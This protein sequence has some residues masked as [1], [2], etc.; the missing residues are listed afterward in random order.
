MLS[1]HDLIEAWDDTML[2]LWNKGRNWGLSANGSLFV[3]LDQI[4]WCRAVD[5]LRRR[6]RFKDVG[7][8]LEEA[9][10]TIADRMQGDPVA[11]AGLLGEV[12]VAIQGL[13]PKRRIVWETYD[14]LGFEASLAEITAAV[15]RRLG[16]EIS[17]T[18]VRKR[19][20]A[21]RWVLRER[22]THQFSEWF[23]DRFD[24][25]LRQRFEEWSKRTFK[26]CGEEAACADDGDES[27]G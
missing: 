26:A 14:E 13:T 7:H 18:T 2:T 3:L 22:L 12:R 11:F 15:S 27:D 1:S 6:S 16:R 19:L 20:E 9:L 4:A 8:Q 10:D 23:G 17:R 24:S 21:G 25:W 5:L